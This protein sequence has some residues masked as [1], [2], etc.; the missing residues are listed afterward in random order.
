[1]ILVN[2][3]EIISSNK[4]LRL[5]EV[6]GYI[7]AG[8]GRYIIICLPSS[9]ILNLIGDVIVEQSDK[10]LLYILKN[11]EE[12]DRIYD[13]YEA[14]GYFYKENGIYHYIEETPEILKRYLDRKNSLT[15]LLIEDNSVEIVE[16]TEEEIK[17]IK[18]KMRKKRNSDSFYY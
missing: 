5:L 8:E 15:T 10:E 7:K 18:D 16:P 6:S 12:I 4:N 17:L 1:M 11:I 3:N 13:K 14:A 2:Q 9:L